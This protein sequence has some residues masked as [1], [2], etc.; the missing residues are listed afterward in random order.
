[1]EVDSSADGLLISGT[2]KGSEGGRVSGPGVTATWDTRDNNMYPTGGSYH[3]FTVVNAAESF[4]SDYSYSAALVD[5]RHYRQILEDKILALRGI[6]GLGFNDPP[7]QLM[8]TLGTHLRGYKI[9]RFRDKNIIVFQTEYRQ[10]LFG[11]FGYILS[12]GFGQVAEDVG[13]V[14]LGELKPSIGF[15]I[16]FALIP[17]HKFNLRIDLG[18]GMDDSSFDINFGEAF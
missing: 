16:R 9:P 4:G 1:M 6:V 13:Q 14:S 8:W 12:G 2:F 15:G 10:H 18:I 5:L 17:Q 11:R 7:F 3:Q